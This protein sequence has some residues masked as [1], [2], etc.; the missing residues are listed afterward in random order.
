MPTVKTLGEKLLPLPVAVKILE[1][2][3]REGELSNIEMITLEYARRFSKMSA[4]DAERLMEELTET[5]L[6]AEVAVQIV[7][8]APESEGE[9]RA[10]LAQQS[11][12]FTSEEVRELL[13]KVNKY[14]KR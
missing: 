9:L 11:R 12:A 10:I 1:E 8:I 13:S 3:A 5:G 2:K 6:P 4:E 14:A 7:N